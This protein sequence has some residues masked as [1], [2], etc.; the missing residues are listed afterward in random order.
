MKKKINIKNYLYIL[1]VSLIILLITSKNS[2]LYAFNDWFD[3]N[4]FFT[5]GKSIFNNVIPYK[6]LFEQKGFILY[7]IYGIG[8]LIDHNG[9]FGVFI[10][11]VIS[12]SI[13]LFCNYKI[14]NLY[15][16]KKYSNIIIPMYAVLICTST[17]FVQ[18]GS[19][20]E[21]AFPF[22][23]IAFYYFIKHFKQ[24]E[25]SKKE[26]FTIGLL[27]GI[28]SLLKYT[29]LGLWIGISIIIILDFIK[30]KDLKKIINYI[31][32]FILGMIIPILLTV[33]YFIINNSLKEFIECYI[34]FNIKFYPEKMPFIE[35][36]IDLYKGLMNTLL[37]NIPIMFMLMYLPF[38]MRKIE[39]N[40]KVKRGIIF[41]LICILFPIYVIGHR[42]YP[43]YLLSICP[44]LIIPIISLVSEIKTFLDKKIIYV[45]VPIICIILSVVGANY[46]E[47]LFSKKED[48]FQ[49]KYANF[50]NQ[51]KDPT[52]LNMETLDAGL[53]TTTGIVPNKRYF[54]VQNI[55]Y[56]IYPDNLDEM[57]NYIKNKEVDFILLCSIEDIDII[58]EYRKEITD[59]YELVYNDKHTFEDN[60]ELYAYLFKLK[61]LKK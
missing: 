55:D 43:Y 19:C 58:K 59:N 45:S 35:S 8:Y 23:S 3:A 57:R 47:Q 14:I 12:F 6:D 48:F 2:P 20:E 56:N 46:R 54:E 49:Y 16:D 15:L 7:L 30:K 31:K 27:A 9:F 5:V 44:L 50:I 26:I 13:F 32:Y 17:S 29:L 39:D 34:T 41:I 11:E 61:S 1:S 4:A 25:L 53:Y 18:G 60:I 21:F 42:Y 38:S 24:N 40:K 22:M 10:L 33:I 36:I 28:V 51:Y 52:L 37:R